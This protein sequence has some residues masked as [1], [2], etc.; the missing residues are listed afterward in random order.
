MKDITVGRQI[1]LGGGLFVAA[2]VTSNPKSPGRAMAD[3]SRARTVRERQNENRQSSG[4]ELH[5]WKH[6]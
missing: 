1:G 5:T 6:S 3:A 2:M 4:K